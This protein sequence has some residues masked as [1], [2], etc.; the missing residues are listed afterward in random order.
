MT[1]DLAREE[2]VI[3]SSKKS[4]PISG[5]VRPDFELVRQE[6]IRNFE[7][8][9]EQG[10][11]C[12]IFFRGTKVVDL[13]GG[14]QCQIA[15]K[16]WSDQTMSV[17]F[18]VTKGMAAAAMVV[19]HS[20]GMFELDRPVSQYW[21][22]FARHGK[23][24]ITVREL[25]SHQ[26]GLITVEPSLSAEELRDHDQLAETLADQKTHWKPG[27][28]HGYHTLTL[29]WYQNELLR[30]TDPKQRTLGQFFQE[31]IAERLGVDFFI[32]LPEH[33]P[34][35]RLSN[36]Q[37]YHRLAVLGHLNQLP[38]MMV[39]SGIWPRS[40]VSKSIRTLPISNPA[41]VGG[42]EYRH[43]EIPSA[44]GIGQ[45]RA[46]AKI[47]DVLARGGSDLG[48]NPSTWNE[49]VAR[50]SVPPA[51]SRDA[52]LK[53]DTNYGFGFSRPSQGFA[54]GT[55]SS[56]F[57]CPGV[58]G[59]FGMADPSAELGFSY[60]TNT[61]S[62]RIFDDPREQAVRRACYQCIENLQYQRR[63]A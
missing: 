39:L 7:A 34:E 32:G 5:S 1:H 57:G 49:L 60:L 52:I 2:T 59:S 6:F 63:A 51:G 28:R 12:A 55:D 17:A 22:E 46:I 18:S 21:P 9:G 50:P 53:L 29:G 26:A 23:E 62:F 61:L 56:A 54:F 45:A 43:V 8:R 19:A 35:E 25:L 16:K 37:G 15:K 48:I 44:N 42:P 24:R 13:W 4:H 33:V 41:D 30:R 58:G 40:L 47:Y 3:F 20:Q 36:V 38:P 14:Y 27:T 10:A 11:A 31:E